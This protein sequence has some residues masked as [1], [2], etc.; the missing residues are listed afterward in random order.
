MTTKHFWI[1]VACLYGMG[2]AAAVSIAGSQPTSP[3][4]WTRLIAVP[5]VWAVGPTGLTFVWL[6]LKRWNLDAAR[7]GL[8]VFAGLYLL[9]IFIR[10]WWRQIGPG[11]TSCA[12]RFLAPSVSLKHLKNQ[13]KTP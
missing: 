13:E 2:L 4:G 1:G 8:A 6:V 10:W 9:I 7:F 11:S 12:E 5:F 3:T